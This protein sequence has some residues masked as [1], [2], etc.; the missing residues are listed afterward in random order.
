MA[1]A[2]GGEGVELVDQAGF[3]YL[4]LQFQ[5]D[6]LVGATSIGWTDHVGVM[7]GLVEGQ[8]RLGPWKDRLLDDPTKLMEAY[9]ARAQAINESNPRARLF[10]AVC[11]REQGLYEEA[12][13]ELDPLVKASGPLAAQ[14]AVELGRTY[15]AMDDPARATQSLTQ[16]VQLGASDAALYTLQA[17]AYARAGEDVAARDAF[18][19][20]IQADT[21]YA[22]AHLEFGLYF[23]ETGNPAEAVGRF[24]RYL[25]LTDPASKD[26]RAEEVRTLLTQLKESLKSSR[27]IK[28]NK[29]QKCDSI[30]VG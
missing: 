18:R 12:I 25:E 3:R 24:E 17:R 20:A 14:A 28:L 7:R 30:N 22:P 19:K 6:V 21:K 29:I 23:L 4:S 26:T 11:Q 13:Q 15:L 27:N 9:L 10:L 16:A 8:V 1:S 2:D 5:Q